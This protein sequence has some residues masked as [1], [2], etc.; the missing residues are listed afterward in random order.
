MKRFFMLLVSIAALSLVLGGC[1]KDEGGGAEKKEEAAKPA[2]EGKAPAETPPPAEEKK[3][4]AAP[5]AGGT[6]V[7]TGVEECDK[8][9][10]QYMKC[11]KLPQ[12]SRDA[13]MQG[14]EAWKKSIEAGG[15]AAKT[16]LADSCKQA[17]E[18]SKQALAAVGC[19]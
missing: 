9:I 8:L 1:K 3:E 19:E 13:F 7:T 2:D 16:A 10:E 11:D 6:A 5:A 12:Q 18:A 14:A 4:E 17:A 15:D